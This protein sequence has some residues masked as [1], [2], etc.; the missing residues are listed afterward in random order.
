M[1]MAVVAGGDIGGDVGFAQGHGFAVVGVA[2]MLQP[3][4]VA[5]AAGAI[6]GH[7]EVAV[8]GRL[9][10]VGAMA[11]GAD[12]SALVALG[13]ELAMDTLEVGLFDADMAFRSEEHTSELQSPMYLV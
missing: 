5:F 7:L 2:I 12:R 13:Q 11:I 3:I 6:A 1:A 4:R 10:L 8:L 9:D